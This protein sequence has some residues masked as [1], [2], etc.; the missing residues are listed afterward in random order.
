MSI[1]DEI[2]LP[3]PADGAGY[4]PAKTI[5]VA[6]A[7]MHED[8]SLSAVPTG[9][10]EDLYDL[11]AGD[12]LDVSHHF[13]PDVYVQFIN[14]KEV[15]EYV[16]RRFEIVNQNELGIPAQSIAE[17]GKPAET[18]YTVGDAVLVK[19]PR[20]I[21]DALDARRNKEAKARL[22]ALE[23]TAEMLKDT[24]RAGLKAVMT[25]DSSVGGLSPTGEKE[26]SVN[27]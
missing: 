1:L 23:P 14:K 13:G 9:N 26:V 18:A 16:A 7:A 6:G 8:G 19:C 22:N 11:Y 4:A 3:D 2:H 17:Y 10:V 27:G 21:K 25:R 20:K 15:P 12:P 24:Q 5:E